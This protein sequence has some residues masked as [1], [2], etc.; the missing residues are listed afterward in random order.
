MNN[1]TFTKSFLTLLV[2]AILAKAIVDWIGK[3]RDAV[4]DEREV[5]LDFFKRK[6]KTR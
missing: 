5:T 6:Q 1:W 4:H 2:S 3:V